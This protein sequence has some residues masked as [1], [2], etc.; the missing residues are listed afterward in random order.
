MPSTFPPIDKVLS[1]YGGSPQKPKV[2]P[3]PAP[4][5]PP[6]PP[7]DGTLPEWAAGMLQ[8]LQTVEGKLKK[9]DNQI[10]SLETHLKTAEDHIATMEKELKKQNK[11]QL[12]A[13]AAASLNSQK[14]AEELQ[15]QLRELQSQ[16]KEHSL[17]TKKALE[18]SGKIN[19]RVGKLELEMASSSKMLE[20]VQ[21]SA[22]RKVALDAVRAG[23]DSCTQ[24]LEGLKLDAS[25]AL[26]LA[27]AACEAIA[28]AKAQAEEA[29]SSSAAARGAATIA[30]WDFMNTPEAAAAAAKLASQKP[31]ALRKAGAA[32]ISSW[33]LDNGGKDKKKQQTTGMCS[34]LQYLQ[35]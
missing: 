19:E 10:A 21:K 11:S 27:T 9:S 34:L 6:P 24:H 8:R 7:N 5:P 22:D 16:L 26:S 4:P 20:A 23:L 29:S 25:N 1:A 31:A 28:A 32:A 33:N 18:A 30:S 15:R 12:D 3:P 13:A 2:K 14:N 17:E 35:R